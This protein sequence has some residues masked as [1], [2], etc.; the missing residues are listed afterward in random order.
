MATKKIFPLRNDLVFKLVFGQEGS[1]KTSGLG[2]M[3]ALTCD[4]AGDIIVV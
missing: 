2:V 4:I 3:Q 1:E